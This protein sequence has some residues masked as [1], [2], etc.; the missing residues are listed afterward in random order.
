MILVI[1]NFLY[2]AVWNELEKENKEFF[3]AYS[4]SHN[5]DFITEEEAR[6]MIHKIIL[7][8]DHTKNSD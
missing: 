7:D 4:Q 3:E 1:G 5:K 8:N 2:F 6:A